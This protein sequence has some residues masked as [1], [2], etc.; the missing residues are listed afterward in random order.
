MRA[1]GLP[2]RILTA[3]SDSALR[4]PSAWAAGQGIRALA[5]S[6]VEQ[7][8]EALADEL[9]DSNITVF[10]ARL[11][12][13]AADSSASSQ[14][15]ALH[16]LVAQQLRATWALPAAEAHGRILP[17]GR[18]ALEM[19]QDTARGGSV[20][21]SSTDV[22]WALRA[23]AGRAADY[24]A[25]ARPLA[26]AELARA[27]GA[28]EQGLVWCHGA[29]DVIVRVS[30]AAAA[31]ARGNGTASGSFRALRQEPSWPPAE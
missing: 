12:E 30:A 24:P 26:Y 13:A 2:C 22:R 19:K 23:A 27:L 17:V 31:R 29:S 15:D 8:T 25:N 1:S 20:V 3:S 14:G 10:G 5:G 4:S 11:V 28:S 18:P 6:F 21:G 7:Y 9:H 16:E